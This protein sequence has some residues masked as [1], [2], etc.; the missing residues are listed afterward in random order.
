MARSVF[1]TIFASLALAAPGLA[2]NIFELAGTAGLS[3]LATAIEAADLKTTISDTYNLTVFAPTNEAFNNLPTGVLNFL[4]EPENKATLQAVL[5]FHVVSGNVESGDLTDDQIVATLEGGNITIDI[6][7]P[8]VSIIGGAPTNVANVTGADN[9]ADNGV[10]HVINQ[11]LIPDDVLM[12]IRTIVQVAQDTP[13]LSTLVQ[14]VVAGDLVATLSGAGPFTVFAP[15]NDAFSALPTGV[16]DYLLKPE[17]KATLVKVLTY[18]VASGKV[19]S[20]ALS[21]NQIIPTVEG[22]NL[23]IKIESGT[24]SVM[25]GSA[26]N[27]AEVVGAD[28]ATFNGIVHVINAVLIPSDVDLSAVI[29]TVTS[30]AEVTATSST[31][32]ASTSIA[33]L[34]LLAAAQLLTLLL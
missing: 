27:I 26:S 22:Q 6:D 28:V 10:V 24:V 13:A 33:S 30:S 32:S 25:G 19:E 18:H 1:F 34:T 17:N 29:S 5:K 23:T 7:A 31:S 2:E 20:G 3:T 8:T 9:I 15:T 14:A 12:A 16:L 4:L 21:N 11:V